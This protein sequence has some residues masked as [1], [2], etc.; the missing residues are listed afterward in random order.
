MVHQEPNKPESSTDS[1]NALFFA[2]SMKGHVYFNHAINRWLIYE[3]SRWK[4]DNTVRIKEIGMNIATMRQADVKRIENH[5]ERK[6]AFSKAVDLENNARIV[7]MLELAKSDR[8]IADD[9]KHWDIHPYQLGVPN[10]VI[11][12]RN[13]LLFPSKPDYRITM[14][15]AAEFDEAAEA[16]LWEEFINQIFQRDQELIDFIQRQVGYAFTG[17]IN[18]QDF[19]LCHGSGSNGKSVFLNVLRIIAGEYGYNLPFSAL[20]NYHIDPKGHDLA[21]LPG[22]R[23]VTSSETSDTS[24]FNEQRIKTLTGGDPQTVRHLYQEAFTFTP[25]MHLFLASNHLPDVKDDSEGFWRRVRI[26]KFQERFTG[27]SVDLHIQDKLLQEASGILNWIIAGAVKYFN[28]KIAAPASVLLATQEYRADTDPLAQ[29]L[30]EECELSPEDLTQSSD[31]YQKYELFA[32]REHLSKIER[33]SSKKFGQKLKA[34]FSFTRTNAGIF[35]KGI[36]LRKSVGNVGLEP[37]SRNFP[38]RDFMGDSFGK[39]PST[40]HNVPTRPYTQ[41]V[42]EPAEEV[43]S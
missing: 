12:L 41:P 35:Y 20:S 23:F 16:P 17:Y 36:S 22:K 1:G 15:A 2:R 43:I 33:L 5:D 10:G 24:R 42:D 25:Q 14:E 27:D 30:M 29:F 18:E 19:V 7:A 9:G 39:I 4:I 31:L 32:D 3:H 37:F 40:L 6:K 34:K 11:D 13:G 26:V 8:R 28:E 38:T 21:W